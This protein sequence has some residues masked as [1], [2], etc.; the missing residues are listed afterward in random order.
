MPKEIQEL[1]EEFKDVMPE[2]L[3]KKLPPK[4]SIDHR[5]EIYLGSDPLAKAPY[6]LLQDENQE[7]KKQLNELLEAGF[8]QPLKSPYGAPV[9]FVKKKEGDLKMW[10]IIKKL[11]RTDTR[12]PTCVS[13][14]I[15]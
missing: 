9:L 7:L 2:Q 10:Y 4:R 1:L 5:I 3:P 6:R 13:Y 8:I 11:S 14:L 12:Y 15:P